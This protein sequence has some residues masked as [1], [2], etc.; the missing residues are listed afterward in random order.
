MRVG[1]DA[2]KATMIREKGE[3]CFCTKTQIKR[4]P[5]STCR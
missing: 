2:K 5:E 4:R 1:F 3:A